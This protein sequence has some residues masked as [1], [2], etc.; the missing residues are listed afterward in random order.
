MAYL[1][2]DDKDNQGQ[3]PAQNQPGNNNQPLFGGA[4]GGSFAAGAGGDSGGPGGGVGNSTGAA[5]TNIQDY[6]KANPANQG[7]A[8]NLSNYAQDVYGK[9]QQNYD[10]QKSDVE[11]Q[12]NTQV[13]GANLGQDQASQL[14]S[15]AAKVAPVGP[16]AA[17]NSSQYQTAIQAFNPYL[18]S[19]YSGPTSFNYN[20]L[21]DTQSFSNRL[22][23][24]EGFKALLGDVYSKSAGGQL[25]S[26]QAALQNQLDI[27]N[28]YLADAKQKAMNDYS[29][30]QEN[31]SKG[32]ADE[33]TKLGGLTDQYSQQI[34][35]NKD[36]LQGLSPGYKQQVDAAVDQ[37]NNQIQQ[38]GTGKI[39][40]GYTRYRYEGDKPTEANIGG[41][42]TQRNSWNA[43][44]QALGNGDQVIA[45]APTD[46]QMGSWNP[47]EEN[48][49]NGNGS[50]IND[51]SGILGHR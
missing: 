10:K 39:P 24:P 12:A 31:I 25:T 40:Q 17:Q 47:Y 15:N 29:G 21:A 9:E 28:P 11:G 22:G 7:S 37:A 3:Q 34:Q 20:P 18:K 41:V 13:Q 50:W 23:T 27:N 5:W 42:D 2:Q 14:I 19:Q 51:D 49:D 38:A 1:S 45:R 48:H 26:S 44:M 43:I 32:I 4:A 16:N 46:W 6:L 33:N 8:N 35:K 30:L 36:Y